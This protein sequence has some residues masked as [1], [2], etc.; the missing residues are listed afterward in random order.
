MNVLGVKTTLITRD[1]FLRQADS[2]LIPILL[3]SMQKLG[4]DARPGTP[5]TK[6]EKLETGCLR[7]HLSDGT[8][9]DG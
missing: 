8:Y 5:F 9:V 6:V 3:E 7:V 2:E 4:L 1:R